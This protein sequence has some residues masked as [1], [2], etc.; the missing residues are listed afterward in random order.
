M[1]TEFDTAEEIRAAIEGVPYADA[2]RQVTRRLL[3][4]L[5]YEKIVHPAQTTEAEGVLLFSLPAADARG[6]PVMYTCRGHRRDG[7]ARLRLEPTT[8]RRHVAGEPSDSF[9][10]TTFLLEI[11][12]ERPFAPAR[13]AQF[14]GER[15]LRRGLSSPPPRPCATPR[16]TPL[17]RDSP[18]AIPTTRATS[19]GSASTWR[20][21]GA[22]APSS[23]PV[24]VP[25]GS[26]C[27]A[28][29]R[30]SRPP[31]ISLRTRSWRATLVA[32]PCAPG[33]PRLL[34]AI[35]TQIAMSSCPCIR[36]SGST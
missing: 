8:L 10:L 13:L 23:S 14:I 19:R 29:E 11:R 21:T 15:T 7:F 9:S 34:R 26:L 16:T 33:K 20:P 3:E 1:S 24:C 2:K 18:M 6:E 28:L 22:L 30:V 25:T 36:G 27:I 32:I 35:S 12:P 17:S 4:S 31:V 5:L